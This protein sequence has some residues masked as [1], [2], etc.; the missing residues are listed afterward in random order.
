[1][2]VMGLQKST[3]YLTPHP[4]IDASQMAVLIEAKSRAASWMEMLAGST[5]WAIWFQWP[6]TLEVA[7]AVQAVLVSTTHRLPAFC[8][9]LVH[10]QQAGQCGA[11]GQEDCLPT[12]AASEAD[13]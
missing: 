1:M 6:D 3:S 4:A 9:C 10:A 8:V 7:A 2:A 11:Q 12:V 13:G 5:A